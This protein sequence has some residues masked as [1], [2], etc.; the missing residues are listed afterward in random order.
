[1][2]GTE[3]FKVY[4]H[5]SPNGKV[6]IGITKQ[7]VKQRWRDGNGYKTQPLFYRA[8]QKYGWD[9]ITHEILFEGLDKSEAEQKETGILNTSIHNCCTG[10]SKT[11][12]NYHWRYVEVEQECKSMCV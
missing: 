5:T 1:M 4:K 8:I 12:G 11:A 10:K 3:N 7:D 2:A 6:Y 9:N